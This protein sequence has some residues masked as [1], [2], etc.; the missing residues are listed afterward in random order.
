MNKL[1]EPIPGLG[2]EVHG[3]EKGFKQYLEPGRVWRGTFRFIGPLG[4]A[5]TQYPRTEPPEGKDWILDHTSHYWEVSK[6]DLDGNWEAA[7]I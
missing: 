7:D 3:H 6:K 5:G 1:I 2:F 4:G